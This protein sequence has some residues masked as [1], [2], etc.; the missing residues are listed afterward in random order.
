MVLQDQ[1][2][3]VTGAS[4]RLRRGGDAG[5]RAARASRSSRRCATRTRHGPGL[6]A[7]AGARSDRIT[8]TSC[9]VTDR[10]SVDAAVAPGRADLR[11]DRRRVQQRGLRPLRPRRGAPGRRGAAPA[12]HERR[13]ADPGGAG[14]PAGH[15]GARQRQSRQRVVAG[16]AHLRPHDRPLLGLEARRRGDVGGVAV[17]GPGR[18]ASRSRFWSPGCTRRTGRP[19][20]WT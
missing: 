11:P 18:P 14:G 4:R 15:A 1:V 13:R 3:F 8:V 2:V 20:R 17:R 5:A 6:L 10:A 12:R 19:R 7:G 9:D 16:R